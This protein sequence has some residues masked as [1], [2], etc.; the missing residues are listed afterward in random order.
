MEDGL[1]N[2]DLVWKEEVTS[3][4]TEMGYG[5]KYRRIEAIIVTCLGRRSQRG[6]LEDKTLYSDSKS[7]IWITSSGAS[8]E[9]DGEGVPP[10]LLSPQTDLYGPCVQLVKHL[11]AF[12]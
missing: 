5:K 4:N 2:A 1:V 12:G 8:P 3:T 10:V 11:E 7:S 6:H 9:F